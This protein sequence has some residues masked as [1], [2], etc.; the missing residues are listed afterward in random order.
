MNKQRIGNLLKYTAVIIL[1]FIFLIPFLWML[2]TALKSRSEVISST[3]SLFPKKIAWENFKEAWNSA[4][5][6]LMFLNSIIVALAVSFGQ[7]FT[8]ALAGY[9][10]A[11]FQFKGKKIIFSILLATLVIPFQMIVIPI[12]LMF[13]KAGVLDT[14]WALILP[15]IANAFGIFL[16]KQ[17][18][19]TI[20]VSL[21]EAAQID[22]ANSWTILWRIMFPLAKPAAVTLFM[23]TFIAEWNDL[24]KP[25]IFTTTEK[26][27]TIQFGLTVFQEQYA[28]N[29]TLLMAA[30]LFITL[31]VLILFLIGQKQFIEGISSSG[32]K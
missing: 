1:T 14:Y 19:S 10:F 17:F 4:N 7:I 20:P 11:R 29:Y 28:T 2:S 27:R 24:F 25:L 21:E 30:A 9:A 15:N 5:F 23:F 8:S 3:L 31:P 13:N 32:M 6:P 18:Y 12:Y 16:F 26:M 22:G